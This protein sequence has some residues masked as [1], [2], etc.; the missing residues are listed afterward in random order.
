[1]ES[2]RRGQ[3]RR[4]SVRL[5]AST[6]DIDSLGSEYAAVEKVLGKRIRKRGR[7]RTTKYLVQF[8]GYSDKFTMW[9]A[10]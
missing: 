1:M 7:G 6:A 9:T 5:A 2:H 4:R 3:Y 10:A 8:K